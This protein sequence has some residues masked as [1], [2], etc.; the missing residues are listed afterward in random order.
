MTDFNDLLP[1]ITGIGVIFAIFFNFK[2]SKRNDSHD[3]SEIVKKLTKL[4]ATVDSVRDGV[5]DIRIEMRSQQKQINDLT[6]RIVRVEESDKSAHRR[7]DG[8]ERGIKNEREN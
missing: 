2:N 7:M 1:Y 4:S 6:E 8:Y 5:D 3:S